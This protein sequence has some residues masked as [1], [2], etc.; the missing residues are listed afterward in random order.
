[1]SLHIRKVTALAMQ[2][3]K[4]PELVPTCAG[5]RLTLGEP[6]QQR[7]GA[8]C[9]V[10]ASTPALGMLRQE[11]PS[12]DKAKTKNKNKT[13]PKE[14]KNLKTKNTKTRAENFKHL[15]QWFSTCGSYNPFTGV[16][17]QISCI[18]DI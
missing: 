13:K 8:E 12:P 6:Q 1:M 14:K 18:S 15:N 5:L 2:N 16:T 10:M 3:P 17:Y 9:G 4:S 7:H 11:T